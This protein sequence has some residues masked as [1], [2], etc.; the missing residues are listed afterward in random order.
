M[1]EQKMADFGAPSSYVCP[2]D[3]IDT[4][5]STIFNWFGWVENDEFWIEIYVVGLL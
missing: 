3:Y 1:F 2:I 4:Q 5:K